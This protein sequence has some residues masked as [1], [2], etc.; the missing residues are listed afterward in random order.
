VSKVKHTRHD[1]FYRS[2]AKPQMFA[3]IHV[4]VS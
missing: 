1:D 4:V 3:Y 2:S